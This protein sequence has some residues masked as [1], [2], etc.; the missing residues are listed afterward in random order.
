MV[1]VVR[2]IAVKFR[3]PITYLIAS[4]ACVLRVR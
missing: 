1:D 2:L 4:E 3:V